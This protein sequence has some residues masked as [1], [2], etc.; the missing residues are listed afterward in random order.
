MITKCYLLEVCT[1]KNEKHFELKSITSK[2]KRFRRY[3]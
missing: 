1:S 2:L 3:F